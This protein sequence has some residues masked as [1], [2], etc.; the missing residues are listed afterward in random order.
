MEE[1]DTYIGQH[2]V[3]CFLEEKNPKNDPVLSEWISANKQNHS[4]FHKY[5]KI[6]KET[7]NLAEMKQFDTTQAWK[8]VDN[9][10]RRKKGIYLRLQNTAYLLAGM[11]AAS[12][13]LLVVFHFYISQPRVLPNIAVEMR[14]EYGNRSEIILPD[15]SIVK[16]NVGSYINY[17]FNN[18]SQIREITFNGEGF[19]DVSKNNIP[20]VVTTPDGM[21]VTV[22]G[23]KFNLSAYKDDPYIKASLLEGSIEMEH[24]GQKLL[25]SLG[26]MAS[27]DKKTQTMEYFTGDLSHTYGWLNNKLY[28]EDMT[29]TEVCKHLERWYAVNISIV[30]GIGNQIRYTGVLKEETIIDVLDALRQLSRIKY[31]LK[32]K[33]I[34]ISKNET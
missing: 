7:R 8:K 11:A 2:I 3:E 10:N 25:L 29:L 13:L 31:H 16:L 26:Q 9:S 14:T 28:M 24:T 6:W 5:S 17:T 22:L 4:D 27:Y 15:G 19:F 12:V 34:V 20:F 23:T 18:E 1:K 33:N 30:G 21:R 32:G